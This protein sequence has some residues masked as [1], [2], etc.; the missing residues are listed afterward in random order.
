MH[1]KLAPVAQLDRAPGYEP[2]GHEFESYRARQIL[3]P[4]I[5]PYQYALNVQL[6]VKQRG[7]KFNL[8]TMEEQTQKHMQKTV[9]A[10]RVDMAKMRTGR[11]HVGMLDDVM[12]PCYG[13]ELPLPQTATITV[14]DARTILISPWDAANAAAIEKA[15]RESD[16]G[17]NPA[18]GSGGIRVALP[19]LSEERRRDLVKVIGREA[20]TARIALR[21]I[22]RDAIAD[23]K[24]KTKN[25]ELSKD[26]G[27]RLEQSI[28][29]ITDAA[30]ADVDAA[31]EEK[32]RELMTV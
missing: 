25:G 2:G 28:Q 32:K 22:R 8:K 23:I 17:L 10:L 12:V 18:T 6:D 27:H 14:A 21:N 19:L 24:T 7:P 11:A 13:S 31:I 5:A 4:H 26:D 29:K 16:L 9:D 30:T 3:P 15:V 20:E 1:D